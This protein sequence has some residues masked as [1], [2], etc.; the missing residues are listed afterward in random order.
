[1][2]Q[3]NDS[4]FLSVIPVDASLI[5]LDAPIF[6]WKLVRDDDVSGPLEELVLLASPTLTTA[7]MG[8]ACLL[9]VDHQR[10]ELLCFIGADI[11]A[12]VFQEVLL[13]FFCRVMNEAPDAVGRTHLQDHPQGTLNA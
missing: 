4:A 9:A 7:E 6:E 8:P 3:T 13:P 11:D 12:R 1:M 2:V 5:Q 10:R